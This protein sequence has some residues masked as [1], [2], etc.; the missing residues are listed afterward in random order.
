GEDPNGQKSE[1]KFTIS[2]KQLEWDPQLH[3]RLQIAGG[4]THVAIFALEN[5]RYWNPWFSERVQV[6]SPG[7]RWPWPLERV[8]FMKPSGKGQLEKQPGEFLLRRGRTDRP[9]KTFWLYA[10]SEQEAR[11]TAERFIRYA[12]SLADIKVRLAEAELANYR[13]EITDVENEIPKLEEKKKPLEAELAKVKEETYFRNK[14]D[15][16][17]S[18]LE[19]NNLLSAAEVDIIGIQA[20]LDM[21]KELRKKKQKKV[22]ADELFWFLFRMRM[23]EEIELAG[24][25]ARKNAALAYRDKALK[26]LDLAE[27]LESVS[28]Q[29]E[30]KRIVLDDPVIERYE[31]RLPQLRAD[32]RPVEVVDNEVTI[33]PV[34]T[35]TPKPPRSQKKSRR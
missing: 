15:A 4:P 30:H 1:L 23:A 3:Q 28:E 22:E 29:L 17:R 34:V 14:D 2:E 13:K 19:W 18:I 9:G 11:E 33:H 26:F 6:R 5:M 16:Q 24:A 20:K 31:R 21:V 35:E 8:A 10:T 25:L 7:S 12:K 32:V 27:K